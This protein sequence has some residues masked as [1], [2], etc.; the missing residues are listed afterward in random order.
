MR[1]YP[2][3]LVSLLLFSSG[4]RTEELQ[5]SESFDR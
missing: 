1:K 4:E 3:K 5:N 2:V